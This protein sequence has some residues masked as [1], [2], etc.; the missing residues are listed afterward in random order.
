M[1]AYHARLSPSS[2]YQWTECT[3]APQEQEGIPNTSNEA[4]RIG[5][6][7][8]QMCEEVLGGNGLEPHDYLGRELWFNE[9]GREE[10]WSEQW[11]HPTAPDFKVAVTQ[12]MVDQVETGVNFVRQLVATSGGEL[13]VEQR[14]PIGQ[15]TGED[16][17]TGTSDVCIMHGDTCAT[18]D[19]K[20]GRKKVTAYDV[21]TP[22]HTD[23]V[24]GHVPEVVRANLQMACYTLGA[25]EKLG[26]T[27]T[28]VTMVI[29]QPP[30]GHVSEYSCSIEELR[31][32]EEFLRTKAEETR[33][34]PVYAPSFS[35]CFFCRAKDTCTERTRLALT[36]ATTGFEDVEMKPIDPNNIG[37]LYQHVPF[38]K[39]WIASVERV[40]F[41]RLEQGLPVV[42]TDGVAYKLVEGQKGDRE[43]INKELAEEALKKARLR[44][45]QMYTMKLIGPAGAEK[46]A[47]VKRA[48]KGETAVPA[49]IGSTTWAHLQQMIQQ[50]DGKPVIV[51]ETDPKPAIKAKADGFEDV[52]DNCD[53]L[54]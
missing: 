48:K 28:K 33:T 22:A 26:N 46:L 47:K 50:S 6:T 15:F 1:G 21:V 8:H 18:V 23:P 12:E 44:Q 16:G 17:A 10:I 32:V 20:F 43:W 34:S 49:V 25:I 5:T 35:T 9:E 19:F 30:I 11:P 42:R 45:D 31:K 37:P 54:F 27:V 14:V 13:H 51:L 3:A 7:C 40:A 24:E 4:S 38:F 39:D 36:L 29:V 53:D 2:A 52:A 41:E